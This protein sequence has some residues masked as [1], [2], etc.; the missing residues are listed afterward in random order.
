MKLI[1]DENMGEQLVS[2]LRNAGYD[3]FSVFETARGSDDFEVLA[4]AVDEDRILL[5]YDKNDFG[6]LICDRGLP[7]PPAVLLYRIPDLPAAR[8]PQFVADSLAQRSDW[9]GSFWVIEA[10]RTR[11]RSLP[12]WPSDNEGSSRL[13]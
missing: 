6:A 11:S 4:I 9:F 13:G 10:Q 8:R 7:G 2:L 1:L 3:I 12:G 5:T